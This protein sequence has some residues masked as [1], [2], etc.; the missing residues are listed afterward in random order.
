[1]AGSSTSTFVIRWIN[2]LTMILAILV[3][4]F[5]FW[6]STHNDECRRSLTIPVMGLGGVI[7]LMYA[8]A[9]RIRGCLEEHFLL[10]L[11]ISNNAVRGPGGNH[12]LHSACVYHYKYW[13]WSC[14]SWVQI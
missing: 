6:M 12:G 9:G 3:V 7:F 8:V 14:C 4:G 11:D 1:M 2:F 13:N 5:G 10:A